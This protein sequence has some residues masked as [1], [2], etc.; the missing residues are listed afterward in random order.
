VDDA[1]KDKGRAMLVFR[2][3]EAEKFRHATGNYPESEG[4]EV[5]SVDHEELAAFLQF[6][7]CT[8]VA[9]PEPWGEGGED[10]FAA[11]D[12]VGMLEASAPA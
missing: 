6:H 9:M 11:A 4:F 8:H 5:V 3:E 1:D 7:R 12:Y 10:F 2:S